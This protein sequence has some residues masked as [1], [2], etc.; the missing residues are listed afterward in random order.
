MSKPNVGTVLFQVALLALVVA[1]V[2]DTLVRVGLAVVPGM[3]LAQRALA[4]AGRHGA[5]GWTGPERR[6][7]AVVRDYVTEL[8]QHLRDF[9]TTCHLMRSSQMPV[10]AAMER[11]VHIEQ[12]L[13]RILGELVVTAR[14]EATAP[15]TT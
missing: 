15:E 4:A 1:L 6:K 11:A 14:G 10:E 5:T 7:D 9:Y 8:L 12:E 2:D 3:L 13:N